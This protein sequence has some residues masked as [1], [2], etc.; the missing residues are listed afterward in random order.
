MF[1]AHFPFFFSLLWYK[2]GTITLVPSAKPSLNM[3]DLLQTGTSLHVN[4]PQ[5]WEQNKQA[6]TSNDLISAYRDGKKAGAD[7]KE[8]II[9]KQFNI[10][11][12]KAADISEKLLERA[13][14][15]G[16]KVQ[17][18]HLKAEGI[19]LFKSL[20]IVDANDYVSDNFLKIY[21]IGAKIKSQMNTEDFEI[22]F[23]FMPLSEHLNKN[24]LFSDGFFLT[25]EK[26]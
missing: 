22:S 11:I 9:L 18:I 1:F 16:I 15:E 2:Y 6:Y 20:F 17:T 13:T 7:E 3:N 12:D 24:C 14:E 23:S 10:N 5:K 25:Y 8:R 19:S 4:T 26:N 21:N